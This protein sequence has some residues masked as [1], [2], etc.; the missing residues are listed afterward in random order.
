MKR[1]PMGPILGPWFKGMDEAPP[2]PQ[3]S[4]RAVMARL[5][6]VRQRGRWWPLLPAARLDTQSTDGYRSGASDTRVLSALKFAVACVVVATFGS[7]VLAGLLGGPRSE[8]PPLPAAASVQASPWAPTGEPAVRAD[9][10]PGVALTVAEVEPGIL[11]VIDDGVRDLGP[12]PPQLLA[13]R[14]GSIWLR[15]WTY[16]KGRNRHDRLER[17]GDGSVL[18][19]PDRTWISDAAVAPDGT[20]W[21]VTIKYSSR[22]AHLRSFDGVS[23]TDRSPTDR[24]VYVRGVEV[25]PD[26]TVWA[27][28]ARVGEGDDPDAWP[29][30][31]FVGKLGPD[32]W[33]RVGPAA[34]I[35]GSGTELFVPDEGD[36]VLYR[37]R[38]APAP[39]LAMA[40]DDGTWRDLVDGYGIVAAGGAGTVWYLPW[41]D[42]DEL[43]ADD[44]L[45]A[46]TDSRGTLVRVDADGRAEWGPED[47]VPVFHW[48][49][50]GPID[51]EVGRDGS[52]WVTYPTAAPPSPPDQPL[53]PDCEGVAR[54]DGQAWRRYLADHCITQVALAENGVIWVNSWPEDHEQRYHRAGPDQMYVVL[55]K[56]VSA[57]G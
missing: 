35:G 11:R 22:Q 53:P 19:P 20:V 16:G 27:A 8:A 1:Q 17:L 56:L 47:G 7:L 43:D 49:Y 10:L 6:Q 44:D 29:A 3:T 21:A 13:G 54:F 34:P 31:T 55:P 14:D 46:H 30:E 2:D 45:L 9:I 12:L 25:T 24:P 26:G 18:E 38:G 50:K 41:R 37:G 36:P 48:H 5:P 4:T 39:A 40:Y 32:G 23:W 33:E 15:S 57:T 51:L 42:E 52:L 28:W